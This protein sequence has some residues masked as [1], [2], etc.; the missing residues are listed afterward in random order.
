ME[1]ECDAE[2]DKERGENCSQAGANGS[3]G[4]PH[5][6]AYKDTDISGKDTRTALCN[7]YQVNKLVF[8][9]PLF[10]YYDFVLNNRNHSIT[11]AKCKGSNLKEGFEGFPIESFGCW[12]LGVWC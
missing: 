4:L 9:N 2:N 7:S 11:T 10:L 12:I 8:G 5:L 6:I 1:E 3:W